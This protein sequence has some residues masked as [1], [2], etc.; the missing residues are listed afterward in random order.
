[1]SIIEMLHQQYQE[2]CNLEPAP[3]WCFQ[4][5]FP[6][7]FIEDNTFKVSYSANVTLSRVRF[8]DIDDLVP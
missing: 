8:E 7:Q 2:S 3:I 5:E 4:E 6:H 1:M